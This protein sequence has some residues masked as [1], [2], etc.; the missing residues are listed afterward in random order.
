MSKTPNR[1]NTFKPQGRIFST[2]DPKR[3]LDPSILTDIEIAINDGNITKIRDLISTKKIALNVKDE[4]GNSPIHYALTTENP[5]LT[6]DGR[7]DI[8]RLLYDNGCPIAG[9]F[10]KQNITPL[11][12][13]VGL[14]SLKIV[15][16]LVENG[17]ELN[18]KDNVGLTPLHYAI[19]GKTI[20]CKKEKVTKSIYKSKSLGNDN[21]KLI[22]IIN[23]LLSKEN[24]FSQYLSHFKQTLFNIDKMFLEKIFDIKN[25][26]FDDVTK[27]AL[28]DVNQTEKRLKYESRINQLKQQLEDFIRDKISNTLSETKVGFYDEG[29]S[30]TPESPKVIKDRDFIKEIDNL[31]KIIRNIESSINKNRSNVWNKLETLDRSALEIELNLQN[32]IM[33][34]FNFIVN[35]GFFHDDTVEKYD[36]N[37]LLNDLILDNS[38]PTFVKLVEIDNFK[39]ITFD[40]PSFI[41]AV[42]PIVPTAPDTVP[43]GTKRQTKNWKNRNIDIEEVELSV[44]I[45]YFNNG[46]VDSTPVVGSTKGRLLNIYQNKYTSRG[47]PA[48]AELNTAQFMNWVNDYLITPLNLSIIADLRVYNGRIIEIFNALTENLMATIKVLLSE[49][50]NKRYYIPIIKELIPEMLKQLINVTNSLCMIK[51]IKEDKIKNLNKVKTRFG[52][53]LSTYLRNPYSFS[54]EYAFE[55]SQ[56]CIDKINEID[57]LCDAI[58]TDVLKFIEDL[59]KIIEVVNKQSGIYQIK[60]YNTDI[61]SESFSISNSV[62]SFNMNRLKELPINLKEY[63]KISGFESEKISKDLLMRNIQ[64]NFLIQIS[65]TNPIKFLFIDEVP[66]EIKNNPELKLFTPDDNLITVIPPPIGSPPGTNPIY[67]QV[68]TLEEPLNFE[69]DESRTVSGVLTNL[70]VQAEKLD[71][72]GKGLTKDIELTTLSS[73]ENIVDSVNMNKK[74]SI[75]CNKPLDAVRSKSYSLEPSINIVLDEHLSIVK[76]RLIKNILG[77]FTDI[78]Y[79][80]DTN[81]V[82]K[83]LKLEESK[84]KI[85]NIK[86]IIKQKL[87]ETF[88]ESVNYNKVF[89]SILAK[90][91]D[92]ILNSFIQNKID[93]SAL[94]ITKKI[95]KET[96]KISKDIAELYRN[97]GDIIPNEQEVLRV[98]EEGFLIDLSNLEESIADY[99]VE[100]YQETL[101]DLDTSL[102]AAQKLTKTLNTP[103]NQFQNLSIDYSGI[104]KDENT[105]CIKLDT[106]LIVYLIEK[107][108]NLN[109]KD[110]QKLVPLRHIINTLNPKLVEIFLM[111]GAKVSTET[112][113]DYNGLTVLDYTLKVIKNRKITPKTFYGESL[114]FI[115]KRLT[116]NSDFKNNI[117]EHIETGFGQVFYILNH[118]LFLMSKK[119]IRNW[120]YSDYQKLCI[121]LQNNFIISQPCN[122]DVLPL[123]NVSEELFEKIIK[124]SNLT[125]T[126][127]EK[128]VVLKNKKLTIE[129]S[130]SQYLERINSLTAEIDNPETNDIDKLSAEAQRR[131]VQTE[132]TKLEQQLGDIDNKLNILKTNLENDTK[133]IKPRVTDAVKELKKN[134]NL[135]KVVDIYKDVFNKVVNSVDYL[136]LRQV[137]KYSGMEDYKGYN[138]L[139]EEFLKSERVNSVQ[140]IVF[141]LAKLEEK[142]AENPLENKESFDIVSKYYS[143]ILYPFSSDYLELPQDSLLDN[144]ALKVIID[145]ITHTV[146]HVIASS[147]YLSIIK[148]TANYILTVTPKES[149]SENDRR[150]YIKNLIKKLFETDGVLV[151]KLANYI[152]GYFPKVV[153]RYLLEVKYD[154]DD[155]IENIR[156]IS[157]LINPIEDILVNNSNFTISKDSELIK[158]IRSKIFPYYTE[159]LTLTVPKLKISVD[160]FMRYC[161]NKNKEL[162]ITT[163][164]IKKSTYEI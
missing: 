82:T 40:D 148:A 90:T 96:T 60:S 1:F 46:I 21:K 80:G 136:D 146:R 130:I 66:D 137:N 108:A 34:N 109:V 142:L 152:V 8:I 14:Q 79:K 117:I 47:A 155:E 105:D 135:H 100:E 53:L 24:I 33:H 45:L 93:E 26:F 98:G 37:E 48:P 2:T 164:L 95:L 43:R 44:D 149:F 157:Q 57:N 141:S 74:G 83:L 9:N 139:W 68:D 28:L 154:Y 87:Q 23:Y 71:Y 131:R 36:S 86:D 49:V 120:N 15:K 115:E 99:L 52:N 58:Y 7:L 63:S 31:D 16:Y 72:D 78:D 77:V 128:I 64:E 118:Q 12:L 97:A 81:G 134:L 150:E 129:N 160:N 32:I 17:G 25:R 67:N 59:N 124:K 51:R 54:L 27:I 4:Q 119:Y 61:S 41:S 35:E 101:V 123:I 116:G 30:P 133:L 151:P 145:I 22:E 39:D 113:K 89:Y 88:G 38:K 42:E 156:D 85:N 29:W 62:L 102:V 111:K 147:L 158:S 125:S 55:Y 92:I 75:G 144:Y 76:F 5:T 107:G 110:R 138:V 69:P 127:S 13:A 94:I 19:Q 163:Q 3:D 103:T 91:T 10:N 126:L 20:E 121:L 153:T 73:N 132:M 122:Q 112:V 70:D 161:V 65:P 143:S 106:E 56:E 104:D 6:E 50:D 162:N 140:N 114:K 84:N 11:H 159:I 18:R